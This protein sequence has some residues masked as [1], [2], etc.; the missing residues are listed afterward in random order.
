MSF[1]VEPTRFCSGRTMLGEVLGLVG[2]A[3]TLCGLRRIHGL[4]LVFHVGHEAA[5]L[6]GGVGHRLDAAIGEI[7]GVGTCRAPERERSSSRRGKTPNEHEAYIPRTLPPAS[8]VSEAWKWAPVYWSATPYSNWYGW[9]GRSFS[10]YGAGE[11]FGFGAYLG[12]I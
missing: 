5:V 11:Y 6:V 9:G 8:C 10:L 1:V 4:A 3:V 2:V 7:D 12:S